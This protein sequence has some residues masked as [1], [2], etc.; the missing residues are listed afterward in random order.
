VGPIMPLVEYGQSY[1]L[2][3]LTRQMT[4]DGELRRRVVQEGLRGVTSNP[5]IFYHSIA[6]GAH[7]RQRQARD[8][9]WS[10]AGVSIP[11]DYIGAR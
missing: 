6:Y 1:R 3:N 7:P 5:D 2:D 8:A 4:E 9:P 10:A 11:W